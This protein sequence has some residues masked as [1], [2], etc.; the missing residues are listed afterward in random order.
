MIYGQ[1]MMKQNQNQPIMQI[2][3]KI[4][5]LTVQTRFY[6]KSAFLH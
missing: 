4:T 1:T 3:Y 6:C 2:E 5:F